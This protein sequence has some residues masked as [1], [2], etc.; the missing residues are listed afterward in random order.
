MSPARGVDQ[1][2]TCLSSSPVSFQALCFASLFGLSEERNAGRLS[3]AAMGWTD[4]VR[5]HL[6]CGNPTASREEIASFPL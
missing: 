4:L 3:E 6:S 1:I 5:D 2:P